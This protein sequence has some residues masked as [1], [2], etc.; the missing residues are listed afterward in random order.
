MFLSSGNI[1]KQ[2]YCFRGKSQSFGFV[3]NTC[4]IESLLIS[5][6]FYEFSV[7][8]PVFQVLRTDLLFFSCVTCT[9]Q[10]PRDQLHNYQV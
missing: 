2:Q 1:C 8:L 3:F 6:P 9:I 4:M 5:G 7:L 10:G